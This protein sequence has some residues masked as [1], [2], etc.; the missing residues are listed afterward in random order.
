MFSKTLNFGLVVS[1][2]VELW[3]QARLE[4]KAVLGKFDSILLIID[5]GGKDDHIHVEG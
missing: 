2:A 1:P 3:N 5:M 4:S